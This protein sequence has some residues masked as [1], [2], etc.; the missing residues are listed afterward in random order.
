MGLPN[1][2]PAHQRE[3]QQANL[4]VERTVSLL[5]AGRDAGSEY[6]LEHPADRGHIASPLFLHARHGPI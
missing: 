5:R 1:V 4:L 3:L 6:I 2:P